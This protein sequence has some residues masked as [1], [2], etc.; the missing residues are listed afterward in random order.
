MFWWLRRDDKRG[1]NDRD[2]RCK[3]WY[4]D[5]SGSRVG[6]TLERCPV[7][8]P[9]PVKIEKPT[10]DYWTDLGGPGTSRGDYY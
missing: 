9:V 10:G 6:V 1:H 5:R 3:F 4:G 2:Y 8:N 7:C